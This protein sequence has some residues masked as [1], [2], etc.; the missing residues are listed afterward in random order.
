MGRRAFCAEVGPAMVRTPA[1]NEAF[2]REHWDWFRMRFSEPFEGYAKGVHVIEI[3]GQKFSHQN[4]SLAL[5]SAA[6]FTMQ[7]LKDIAALTGFGCA[8]SGKAPHTTSN[9]LHIWPAPGE[10][11]VRDGR[12]NCA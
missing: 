7:R 9:R 6:E 10:R 1:G 11:E 12:S 2:V 5:A 3:P 8:P 4:Q